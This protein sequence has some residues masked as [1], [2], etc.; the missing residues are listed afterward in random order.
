MK[1][2]IYS[3][4]WDADS[5]LSAFGLTV[6][7]LQKPVRVGH[8]GLVSCTDNDPPFVRGFT[9]WAHTLRSL[10]E[11]LIPLG[12]KRDNSANYAR[13]FSDK[14]CINIIVASGDAA[15]GCGHLAP[16]TKSPKGTRAENSVLGNAQGL[17]AGFLPD[18]N[19]EEGLTP[20]SSGY[21]TWIFLVF[22][23][24]AAVR[25]ELS[26]PITIKAGNIE[27]WRERIL[28]PDIAVGPDDSLDLTLADLGPDFPVDVRRKA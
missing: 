8:L 6:D 16:K 10:R 5:R 13:T 27:S 21:P 28:L 26:F 18:L 1:P 20:D 12:W 4:R 25:A 9:A 11:L 19:Q 22:I 7:I 17:L 15:T 3:Q 2:I 14:H 23:T 24:E